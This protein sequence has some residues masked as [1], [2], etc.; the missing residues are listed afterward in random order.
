MIDLGMF[1]ISHVLELTD[2]DPRIIAV[3]LINVMLE[4]SALVLLLAVLY[5]GFQFLMSFGK[6][7]KIKKAT[8]TI[9][10]AF[11]GMAL[12]ALSWGIA[13]FVLVSISR[14]VSGDAAVGS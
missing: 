7:D 5:G 14:A 12:V 3:R 4:F 1:E 6:A 2:Q 8:A 10:N 13:K 11:I 9:V